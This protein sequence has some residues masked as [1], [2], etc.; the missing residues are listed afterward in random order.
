MIMQFMLERKKVITS[1]TIIIWFCK[2]STLKKCIQGLI[3]IIQ[4]FYKGINIFDKK[5]NN[6]L[7]VNQY[8]YLNSKIN[9]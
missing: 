5:L 1:Q 8:Y 9:N 7:I 2:K 6:N 4:Y 3:L